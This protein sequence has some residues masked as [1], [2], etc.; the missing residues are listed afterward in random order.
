MI[1]SLYTLL[2]FLTQIII[3]KHSLGLGNIHLYLLYTT[4]LAIYL[5]ISI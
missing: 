5:Y 2:L 3:S 1:K 4:S